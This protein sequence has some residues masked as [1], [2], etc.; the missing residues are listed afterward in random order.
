M[1]MTSDKK[2]SKKQLYIAAIAAVFL[3]AVFVRVFRFGAVPGGMNQDG[4][5]AAVDAKALAEYGTD[6]LG[7]FRPVHLTAWGFG[8][9]SAL[10]SYLEAPLIRL[11]GL[12]VVTARLPQLLVSLA[13]L[14][15]LLLFAEDSFSRV[16]A[17]AIFFFGAI[18]PWHIM[19][20]RWAL[21][22]NLFPH[23]LMAGMFF[24]GRA[25][26]GKRSTLNLCISM[27]LFGMSMYCYGISIYTVPLF[28][29]AAGIFLLCKKAVS[30][31]Q[32]FV[33]AGV[34][35]AVSW[36]F[37]TCMIINAFALDTIETPFFTI[38]RFY[39][40]VRSAD[41]LFFSPNP[42]SQ[43]KVNALST[44]K[45]LFQFYDGLPWNGMKGSGTMYVFSIPFIILGGVKIF[46][47]TKKSTPCALTAFMF[48][49]AVFDGLITAGVNINRI[50]ILFY[51]LI[52]MGGVGISAV[53]LK[54]K[55]AKFI[56]PCLY[57][58]ALCLFC[59][60]YFGPYAESISQ[61]FMEDFG[62]AV[63][64]VSESPAD[65]FYITADSQYR[66]SSHVSE[67][68]TLFYHSVDAE[69]YQSPAF[70]EKYSFAV[71]DEPDESE[72]AVYVVRNYE[73]ERFDPGI[74]DFQQF[75][76]FYTIKKKP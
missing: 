23:F 66:N 1:I 52:I 14:V 2:F 9:M 75:G 11:F 65:R 63:A 50:N 7:M 64:E 25:A 39:S 45:I 42:L 47:R 15:L 24:L 36:P 57:L 58:A 10:L 43:L 34:Y 41:I 46:S 18:N 48:I 56:L 71:P 49:T 4:A 6:R 53:M 62:Q 5:M 20:S 61:S 30:P 67:I 60:R 74:Y 27:V 22:C 55:P 8:Q 59:G 37:I 29:A 12:S 51:P 32:F 28:L 33:S 44:L 13:G 17:L 70:R 72:D 68:L 21:D 38:P 54:L 26:S 31:A 35:L 40:S 19:Q 69:Y 16:T 76:R 73:L 3:I